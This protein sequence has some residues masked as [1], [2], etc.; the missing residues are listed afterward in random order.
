MLKAPKAQI[1]NCLWICIDGQ[2]VLT[3]EYAESFVIAWCISC[4]FVSLLLCLTI[5]EYI[6]KKPFVAQT[7]VDLIYLDTLIYMYLL[8]SG[9]YIGLISCILSPNGIQTISFT[10]SVILSLFTNI[11]L[12]L[13]AVSM[14][15]SGGLRLI[16]MIKNSKESGN[17][18][19]LQFTTWKL[20]S[21]FLKIS[22]LYVIFFCFGGN[23]INFKW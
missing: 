18:F 10:W 22:Q 13:I 12:N 20:S 17:L 11:C 19:N 7:L 23:M 4:L 21:F 2:T 3:M 1:N 16:S 9:A 5:H 15:F 8:A 6:S 14:I